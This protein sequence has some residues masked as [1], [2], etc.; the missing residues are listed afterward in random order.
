MLDFD[1]EMELENAGIDAFDF[2]LMDDDER[3]EALND[4][5]LDPDDY[6]TIEFDSSF[7]AWSKLQDAGLSLSD[8]SYRDEETA[9]E[10]LRD[11]GL[12]P[13]DYDGVSRPSYRY[14]APSRPTSPPPSA[15]APQKP[16]PLT[17]PALSVPAPSAAVPAA[18]AHTATIPSVPVPSPVRAFCQVRFPGSETL[19]SYWADGLGLQP[20][21]RVIVPVGDRGDRAVA[22]VAVTGAC[23]E[24]DAPYPAD[25]M[26]SAERLAK[27]GEDGRC[28]AKSEPKKS[29]PE[30][31]VP[32]GSPASPPQEAAG[33]FQT[34]T[35][36][37]NEAVQKDEEVRDRNKRRRRLILIIA[38]A[39]ALLG[40]IIG[41]RLYDAHKEAKYAAERYESALAYYE[42]GQYRNAYDA[43]NEA[44]RHGLSEQSIPYAELCQAQEL[45]GLRNYNGAIQTYDRVIAA[46][47]SDE[48]TRMAAHLKEDAEGLRADAAQ[49]YLEEGLAYFESHDFKNA[50]SA[51]E[52][53]QEN[54]CGR[55]VTL[56]L[57]Y[58]EA[59][60]EY[61]AGRYEKAVSYCESITQRSKTGELASL[62]VE[63][64]HSAKTRIAQIKQEEADRKAAEQAKMRRYLSTRLP[65]VGMPVEYL[66]D[67]VL[68][69][70]THEFTNTYT[71]HGKEVTMD[72]YS[73]YSPLYGSYEVRCAF[74]KVTYVHKKARRTTSLTSSDYDYY[75]DEDAD[76]YYADEFASAADFYEY[77]RDD[78]YDFE[79]A[80]DYYYEHGGW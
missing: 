31:P 50:R 49:A 55:D 2:S 21:D 40:T 62:A 1:R 24:N 28:P 43:F 51:L 75:D 17:P 47:Y 69:K 66:N 22:T 23:A 14:Y 77:Y 58:C 53:A 27:D 45:V 20:G 26:K 32:S 78:F 64:R 73:Y 44:A 65:Y 59:Q 34:E 80:E 61:S 4:A 70:A 76:E 38:A 13:D 25:R 46:G 5:G 33:S 37:K 11:A 71:D 79:E 16:V 12:D 29:I 15:A 72:V 7:D 19:Y 68:G 41:T 60:I 57:L 10:K 48:F 30:T 63:L 39:V 67:T 74:G 42:N 54:G 9:R 52:K 3:R 18:Y 35:D 8:L 36:R 6:E 56:H